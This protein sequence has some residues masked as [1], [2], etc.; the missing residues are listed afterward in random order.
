M[1]CRLFEYYNLLGLSPKNNLTGFLGYSSRYMRHFQ[2]GRGSVQLGFVHGMVRVMLA[3]GWLR[4]ASGPFLGNNLFPLKV[5]LRWVFVNGLKCEMGPK[6]GQKWVFGCKSGSKCVKT[7][8]APTLNQFRHIHE[9]PLFTQ[10]KGGRKRFPKRALRQPRPSIRFERFR[11]SVPTGPLGKVSP[12]SG[13]EET[14]CCRG[15]KIAARQSLTTHTPLIKRVT[16]HP[17]N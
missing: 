13:P 11:F 15:T 7:T 17:L 2:G 6:V 8:F 9:N 3:Q 12:P 14:S 1:I 10:F 5:G 4:A 16:F